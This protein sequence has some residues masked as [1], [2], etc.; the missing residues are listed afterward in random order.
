LQDTALDTAASVTLSEG[1]GGF[2]I[3]AIHFDVTAK[4]PG[5]DQEKFL[6][7]ANT[8]KMKCPVSKALKPDIT[9]DARLED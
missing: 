1:N 4:I 7:A 9:M 8:A 3:S 5:I 6:E 2:E